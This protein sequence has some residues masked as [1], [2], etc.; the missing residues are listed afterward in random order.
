MDADRRSPPSPEKTPLPSNRAFV[1]QLSVESDPDHDL[2]L[3]RV[4]HVGSGERL[5]FGSL[6]ELLAFLA[7][8][9]AALT[10]EA[11]GARA[12]DDEPAP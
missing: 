10:S 7:R 4:E 1:V 5:R 12:D 8:T 9:V 3:G 11:R 6:Q 2:Y